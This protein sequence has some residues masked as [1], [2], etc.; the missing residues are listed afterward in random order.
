MQMVHASH[1][2]S[3]KNYQSKGEKREKPIYRIILQ[4][5]SAAK[6]IQELKAM[7]IQEEGRLKKVKE[8]SVHLTVQTNAGSNKRKPGKNDKRKDKAPT[9]DNVSRVRK[10]VKCFFCKK[11]GHIKKDCQKRKEWFESKGIQYDPN[12]KRT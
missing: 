2:I 12:H 3:R 6:W 1:I 7:L 10:E 11:T 8:H 5:H 9:K 4:S